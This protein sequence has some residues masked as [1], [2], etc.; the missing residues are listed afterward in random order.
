MRS[1]H[2]SRNGFLTSQGYREVAQRA[3]EDA[4][5]DAM[6]TRRYVDK[7]SSVSALVEVEDHHVFDDELLDQQHRRFLNGF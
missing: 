2:Y 7:V 6:Q 1:G 3:C 4:G 5:L